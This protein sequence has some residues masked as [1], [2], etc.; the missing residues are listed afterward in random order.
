MGNVKQLNDYAGKWSVSHRGS[1]TP[2]YITEFVG[3]QSRYNGF[4]SLN[5]G[6][7]GLSLDQVFS[8]VKWMEWSKDNL[9]VE[10]EFCTIADDTAGGCQYVQA[11][12]SGQADE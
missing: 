5:W 4:S 7:F 2:V 9:R 6:F 11:H 10:I 1:F 8:H 12:P 3:F